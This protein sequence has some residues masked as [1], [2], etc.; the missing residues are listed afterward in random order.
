M[1]KLF[2]ILVAGA[3]IAG[4]IAT[5]SAQGAGPKGGQKAGAQGGPGGPGGP[6]GGQGQRNRMGEL[7]K[8]IKP[9]LTADQ[10]KK[11]EAI[12]DKF[13]A[14]MRKLRDAGPNAGGPA[15]GARQGGPGGPGGR[16]N[17][18]KFMEL[19]KKRMDAINK[20]LNKQ[21]QASFKKLTEEMMKRFQQGGRGGGLVPP[22]GKGG[23]PPKPGAGK[24]GS[25]KGG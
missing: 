20:V 18:Q 25:G 22:A 9:P 19:N 10:T 24:T 23:P 2:S 4:L 12:N 6:R 14:E 21:Q 7:M 1:N 16:P 15:G 13:R 8:Q 11:I 17:M 3:L 5:V